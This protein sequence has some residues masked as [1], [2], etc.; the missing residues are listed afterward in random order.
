MAFRQIRET[1]EYSFLNARIKA[2][3]SQLLTTSDYEHLLSV[4][5]EE[6]VNYIQS[7]PRYQGYFDKIDFK[8]SELSFVLE[9]RLKETVYTEME[10]LIPNAPTDAQE[11]FTLY[12]KKPYLQ[13]LE[14]ILQNLHKSPAEPLDLTHMFIASSDERTELELASK[15]VSIEELASYISSEW[16]RNAIR[17]SLMNYR[18]SSNIND[19]IYQLE[20]AFFLELWREKISNLDKRS[21]TIAEKVIGIEVD[22]ANIARIIRKKALQDDPTSI[23][24]MIIP[25]HFRLEVNIKDL[26]NTTSLIQTLSVLDTTYYSDFSKIL[27][28]SYVER[29]SLEMLEQIQQEYFLRALTGIMA[30]Y[31]FHLGI[32]LSYYLYRLQEIENLRIIFESKIKEV[33]LDFT[34]NLLIYFR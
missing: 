17:V 30:G 3:R 28:R 13:V 4:E 14:L 20:R 33:D 26:M 7:L 32:L 16:L 2:R 10:K 18:K 11:F 25:I 31:P 9:K 8:T 24:E 23:E 1:N 19:F 29:N 22:L 6:A 34:R 21:R 12:L 15:A 5:L 27:R